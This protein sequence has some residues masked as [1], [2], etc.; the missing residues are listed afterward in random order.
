M[1]IKCE[2]IQNQHYISMRFGTES[3]YFGTRSRLPLGGRSV[4]NNDFKKG[5]AKSANILIELSTGNCTA[6]L[7]GDDIWLDSKL[8]KQLLF[9]KEE[10]CDFVCTDTLYIDDNDKIQ[11]LHKT[12]SGIFLNWSLN[13]LNHIHHST[14]MWKG[15]FLYDEN[16]FYSLDY[17]LWTRVRKIHTI[18]TLEETTTLYRN[19]P[20]S[21][22][23]SQREEQIKLAN[24]ISKREIE[25][26]L[27]KSFSMQEISNL[28]H[29]FRS[30]HESENEDFQK[31]KKIFLA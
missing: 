31:L 11:H 9:L 20:N 7:D 8:E 23:N 14:V 22:T 13:F 17:E 24:I 2:K 3:L 5:P 25:F 27:N 10:R 19:H 18:K 6:R 15:K 28:Q 26:Y 12:P 16:F 21:I 4:H 29:L 30:N 1:A